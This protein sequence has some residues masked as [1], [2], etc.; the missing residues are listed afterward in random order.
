LG[1]G[2]GR[3]S[4]CGGLLDSRLRPVRLRWLNR[5]L[6]SQQGSIRSPR[7]VRS[8]RRPGSLKSR[9]NQRSLFCD[10]LA[11]SRQFHGCHVGREVGRVACTTTSSTTSS[12]SSCHG[13]SSRSEVRRPASSW[14]LIPVVIATTSSIP[15][16][17]TTARGT[18][19]LLC[20]H[21]VS[22]LLSFLA[23]FVG[24]CVPVFSCG[25]VVRTLIFKMLTDCFLDGCAAVLVLSAKAPDLVR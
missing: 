20:S 24:N 18:T 23:R 7:C 25:S 1:N 14:K 21:N 3:C 2:M 12:A 16:P 22:L 5:A 15:G 17:T 13:T 10:G 6:G 4:S 8:Q 11:S 19:P 9:L